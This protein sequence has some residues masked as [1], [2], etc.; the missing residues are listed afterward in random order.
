[1]VSVIVPIYNAESTINRC[2]ESIVNQTFEDIEIILVNDGSTDDSELHIQNWAKK[3]KRV[4][5]IHQNNQG[6]SEARNV[7]IE[8][9]QGEYIVFA[10]V[11]DWMMP[12]CIEET[13]RRHCPG[14]LTI[15]GYYADFVDDEGLIKH[16]KI[17]VNSENEKDYLV[18]SKI[19]DLFCKGLFG[20]VWNKLYE[21]DAIK[22]NN[23]KFDSQMNLGEDIVFNVEYIEKGIKEICVINNPLYH[24]IE[25]ASGSLSSSYNARFLESQKIIYKK[26][27]TT[28]VNNDADIADF[29]K[30]YFGELAA[31]IVAIDNAYKYKELFSKRGYG[32]IVD[33]VVNT[34]KDESLVSQIDNKVFKFIAAIRLFL[35]AH[36]LFFVDFYIREILKRMLGLR[37]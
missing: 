35:I 28:L 27:K 19:Y 20:S 33:K 4:K 21:A 16:T 13:M 15:F 12:N 2:V 29:D 8:T 11:D 26:F 9:A 31:Y 18:L 14:N 17:R 37:H 5:A 22:K 3:D 10:D 24:Y 36:R 34:I 32:A 1:M 7:G 30:L 6:V 23:I 25:N